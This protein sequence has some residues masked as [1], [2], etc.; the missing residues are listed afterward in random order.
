MELIQ[1]LFDEAINKIKP[2]IEWLAFFVFA[3]SSDMIAV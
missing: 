1:K 3:Y 2:I